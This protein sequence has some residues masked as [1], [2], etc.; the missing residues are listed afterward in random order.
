MKR[1]KLQEPIDSIGFQVLMYTVAL[2]AVT[3][4]IEFSTGFNWSIL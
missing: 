2:C 1:F 3:M 4:F